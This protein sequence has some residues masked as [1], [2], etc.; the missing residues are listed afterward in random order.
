M[1]HTKGKWKMRR[2]F[3]D[4]ILVKDEE[5]NREWFSN[6]LTIHGEDDRTICQVQFQTDTP[7]Q[8]FGHNNTTELF[9]ANAKLISKSPEMHEAVKLYIMD[10]KNIVPESPARNSRIEQ[11]K[12]LLNE[13]DNETL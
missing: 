10:L 13:I 8:G 12:S 11:I 3:G 2:M 6:T 1:K 7:N 5:G 9:E 4:P